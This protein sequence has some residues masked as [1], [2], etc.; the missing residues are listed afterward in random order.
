[1]PLDGSDDDDDR[2]HHDQ[3]Q[4]DDEHTDGAQ[5]GWTSK[6]VRGHARFML[7]VW[8]GGGAQAASCLVITVC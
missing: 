6:C 7:A 1:M 5:T 3:T 4:G 2:R 8:A